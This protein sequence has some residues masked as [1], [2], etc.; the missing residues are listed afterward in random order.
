MET[1]YPY[2]RKAKTLAG[3]VG[4]SFLLASG[5]NLFISPHNLA[6]GGVTGVTIV[7]QSLTG[8][9]L[10]VSNLA[11]SVLVTLVGWRVLGRNFLVNTLIPTFATSFF[12]WLT[13]GLTA[14]S[15]HTLISIPL[16]AITMGLGI[17]IVMAVGGSTAGTDTVA[18]ALNKKFNTSGTLMMKIIDTA[19]ILLGFYIYG[20]QTSLCS[21]VVAV[22]MA[23]T[24]KRVLKIAKKA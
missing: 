1:H 19:V 16:G 2:L 15:P 5:V 20:L 24:V 18:L 10:A 3:L 11:L 12:L 4:G 13:D 9:P 22:V 21:V 17:G 7:I 23:E 14:Y 6:F 8:I